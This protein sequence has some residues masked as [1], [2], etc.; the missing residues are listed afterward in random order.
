MKQEVH[1]I[2]HPRSRS[3]RGGVG[4]GGGGGGGGTGLGGGHTRLMETPNQVVIVLRCVFVT[5]PLNLCFPWNQVTK[6][7][8]NISLS[9]KQ[10]YIY[11]KAPLIT[12]LI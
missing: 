3:G 7:T 10:F 4:L 8:M 1:N 11:F 2:P 9:R 5:I 12:F 6:V